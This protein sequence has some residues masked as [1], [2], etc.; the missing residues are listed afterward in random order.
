MGGVRWSWIEH[1][2]D[3]CLG[4]WNSI[5]DVLFLNPVMSQSMRVGRRVNPG[6][7]TG[8]A[9]VGCVQLLLVNQVSLLL[10][11]SDKWVW[12]SLHKCDRHT[13]FV[14]AVR[15]GDRLIESATSAY[16]A[17]LLVR[18]SLRH[19]HGSGEPRPAQVDDC[20]SRT[21]RHNKR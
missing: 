21:E 8:A 15:D 9:V 20:A 19:C 6:R 7:W 13:K 14:I 10:L 17:R 18:G 2:A 11:L 16:A 5:R 1:E 4:R 12:A 3:R